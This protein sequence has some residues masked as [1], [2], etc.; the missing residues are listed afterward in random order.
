MTGPTPTPTPGWYPNPDGSGAQRYWDG[1]Q[2]GETKP[3]EKQK[4][5]RK[6]PY[7]AAAA[8]ALLVVISVANGGDNSKD[9][10]TKP[11]ATGGTGNT[12]AA[13]G[14]EPAAAPANGDNG[15]GIGASVRDGKFEFVVTSID[16]SATAGDPTNPYLQ[17]TATGEFFN[18][19]L[20]VHNIGDRAQQYFASN[21]KLTVD[22][23]QYDA[24]TIVGLQ[25]DLATINPGLSVD[26]VVSFD[27]PPGSQP[28]AVVLHDSAFSRGVTVNLG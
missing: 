22:G 12:Q 28:E 1:Q 2:W 4:K 25:G 23:K 19:H 9:T 27:V 20:T 5:R 24:A 8:F 7:I 14:S 16:R 17:Q 15:A 3:A 10:S 13:T 18:V 26:T 6:W 11:D 21:Q